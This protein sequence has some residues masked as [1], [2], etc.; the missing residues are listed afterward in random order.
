MGISLSE[1][2]W[3]SSYVGLIIRVPLGAFFILDGRMKMMRLA[4]HVANIKALETLSEQNA[5]LYGVLEPYAEVGIGLLLVA[6]MWT[7][8]AGIAAAALLLAS[9]TVY[10]NVNMSAEFAAKYPNI[11]GRTFAYFLNKDFVLLGGALAL[12][13]SGS[14]TMSIDGFRKS[15]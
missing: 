9:F 4:E 7:T 11:L 10:P 14:G 15:S 13:G 6:G 3:N 2:I 5:T 1:P 8:L 12:L